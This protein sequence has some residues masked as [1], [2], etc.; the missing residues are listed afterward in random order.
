MNRQHF[1][2]GS[3]FHSNRNHFAWPWQKRRAVSRSVRDLN[4]AWISWKHPQSISSKGF[5]MRIGNQP[6]GMNQWHRHV[7]P[8]V[9]SSRTWRRSSSNGHGQHINDGWGSH[10]TY[11]N[12]EWDVWTEVDGR[13]GTNKREDQSRFSFTNNSGCIATVSVLESACQSFPIECQ[14]GIGHLI[15]KY[16]D[17]LDVN[18][19]RSSPFI[20]VFE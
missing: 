20:G 13:R 4:G 7:C 9:L 18:Y 19:E 6:N 12:K 17:S 10:N 2:L 14:C 8:W 1:L 15:Q 3:P 11:L 16:I 5:G